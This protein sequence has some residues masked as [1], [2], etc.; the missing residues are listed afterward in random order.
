MI[1]RGF[2]LARMRV[3]DG[4]A[5]PGSVPTVSLGAASSATTTNGRLGWRAGTRYHRR[6][7]Q[8]DG[9][10]PCALLHIPR[11]DARADSHPDRE[12][13]LAWVGSRPDRI[14]G[15][16]KPVALWHRRTRVG[17]FRAEERR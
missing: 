14:P 16:A 15:L 2:I 8:R 10:R 12:L 5:T 3:G 13:P 17:P 6:Q 7:R 9:E 4:V 1:G 11:Y